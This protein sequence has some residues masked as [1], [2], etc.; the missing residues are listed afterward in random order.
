M[1][2]SFPCHQTKRPLTPVAHNPFVWH[3][4]KLLM[5]YMFIC[6]QPHCLSNIQMINLSILSK[7]V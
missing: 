5:M 3:P 6:R 1:F 2:R 7:K 4:V